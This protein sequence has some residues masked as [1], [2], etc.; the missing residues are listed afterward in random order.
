VRSSLFKRLRGG[1]QSG[2]NHGPTG[3]LVAIGRRQ[4]VWR[5]RLQQ[6]QRSSSSSRSPE[7]QV[8]A[9]GGVVDCLARAGDGGRERRMTS[10][11]VEYRRVDGAR[12]A[13]DVGHGGVSARRRGQLFYGT[14]AANDIGPR[15]VAPRHLELS[16]PHRC[17][18][19]AVYL[20][21]GRGRRRVAA[22][23]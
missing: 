10:A 12:A 19:L 5:P 17:N 8:L 11:M 1:A 13:H 23:A 4:K 21:R 2:Q 16:E 9:D 3:T 20:P 6:S 7:P 14:R 18:A 22:H 15:A